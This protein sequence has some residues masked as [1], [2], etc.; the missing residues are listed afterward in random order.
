MLSVVPNSK[1]REY[2]EVCLTF[3]FVVGRNSV[4]QVSLGPERVHSVSWGDSGF[5]FWLTLVSV[6]E[7]RVLEGLALV[8]KCFSLEVKGI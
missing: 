7:G 4:F 6:P 5:Y 2:A 8:T 1:R 3:L